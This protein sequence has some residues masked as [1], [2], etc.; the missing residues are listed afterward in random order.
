MISILLLILPILF[1]LFILAGPKQNTAKIATII[2]LS[3]L[4]LSVYAYLEFMNHGAVYFSFDYEWIK[5][6]SIH[7]KFTVDG[8]ALLLIILTNLCI[9]FVHLSAHSRKIEHPRIYHFLIFLIQAALIGVFIADDLLLYYVFWELTIIPAY[10]LLLYWGG[11]NRRRITLKFFL[12]TVFGSLLMMV[13]IF[14]IYANYSQGGALDSISIY[15]INVEPTKQNW[16]F[17]GFMIAFAVKLPLIPFHTWQANTYQMAPGQG[18]MIL[19]GLLAKMA[20]FS[21]VRWLIPGLQEA[22]IRFAPYIVLFAVLGVIYAGVIAIM[23][24]NLK[25]MFAYVSLAHISLMVA[26]VFSLNYAGIQ[27]AFVQ[28]FSHG[29]NTIAL[30]ICVDM[31]QKRTGVTQID[32]LGGIRKLAPKFTTAFFIVMLATAAI[33]FSNSFVGELVVL[34]GIFQ[35]SNMMAYIAVFSL[36]LG[37]VF[38]LRMFRQT[39][40]GPTNTNTAGFADLTKTEMLTIYPFVVLIFV[41][42]LVYQPLFDLTSKPVTKLIQDLWPL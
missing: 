1:S 10:F 26:G 5:N 34:Y 8:I 3:S 39:I 42:G 15:N 31:I 2:S 33:P 24:K 7:I 4:I 16:L 35:S 17:I 14:Y 11:Q 41:F 27:G 21:M 19:A 23:Q 30:F 22:T 9:P 25:R 29:I 32:K 38:M 18:T 36:V 40:L 37:A 20:L 6:P 12:Y 28:A 13:A